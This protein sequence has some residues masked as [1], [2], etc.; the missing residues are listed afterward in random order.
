MNRFS[1]TLCALLAGIFVLFSLCACSTTDAEADATTAQVEKTA[2]QTAATTN[3]NAYRTLKMVVTNLEIKAT[4]E[5]VIYGYLS[6]KPT[7]RTSFKFDKGVVSR[8]IYKASQRNS[9]SEV[10]FKSSPSTGQRAYL[11]SG[12]TIEFLIIVFKNYDY[13]P[14]LKEREFMERE[15]INYMWE[16]ST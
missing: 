1:R 12:D 5:A 7:E 11:E 15:G 14:N 13:T 16:P 3:P 6:T 2:K 10:K 8:F 9:F 4:G